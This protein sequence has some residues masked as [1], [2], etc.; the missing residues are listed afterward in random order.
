MPGHHD[1][2]KMKKHLNDA[3]KALD[4]LTA[5]DAADKKYN[6]LLEVAAIHFELAVLDFRRLCEKNKMPACENTSSG[7]LLHSNEVYGEVEITDSGWLHIRLNT[8]LPGSRLIKNSRYVS[9]SVTRLLNNFVAYGG[10]LPFLEKA[11]LAIIERCDFDSRRSYD[12]DN[13]AFTPVVNALKGR[14][15]AD[16]DQFEL[17]LGLFTELDSENACHIFV[18]AESEAGDFFDWR[19]NNK[20]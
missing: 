10:T 7:T 6:E 16:D 15:Y 13:K 8:L 18:M 1:L 19:Q 2:I 11:F 12:Q 14:L 4:Y 3:Q 20:L 9:D 17:S 5:N